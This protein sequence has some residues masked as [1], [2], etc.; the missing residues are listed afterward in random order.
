M[1]HINKFRVVIR[2]EQGKYASK[3]NLLRVAMELAKLEN[4]NV[5]L[6]TLRLTLKG[7]TYNSTNSQN[8]ISLPIR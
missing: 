2:M 3:P 6:E 4:P 7:G 5:V 1:N 8:D